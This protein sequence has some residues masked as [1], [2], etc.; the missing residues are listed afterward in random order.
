MRRAIRAI[1]NVSTTASPLTVAA[2]T[3]FDLSPT[4]GTAEVRIQAGPRG[5]SLGF[6][7]GAK[8]QRGL[9]AKM[10]GRGFP[11][12]ENLCLKIAFSG[13]FCRPV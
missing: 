5:R 9:V 11:L 4:D 3:D 2:S 12:Q 10:S 8:T 1:M 6:R 7:L 13:A